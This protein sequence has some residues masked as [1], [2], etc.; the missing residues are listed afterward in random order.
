MRARALGAVAP[1]VERYRRDPSQPGG[2]LGAALLALDKPPGISSHGV[3][4]RVRRALRLRAVGHLGTLDPNASGLL[5]CAL[6][7]C[8][9]AAQ[10]WQGGDKTYRGTLVLGVVTDSQDL[11]GRV[12]ER[13]PAAVDEHAVR[14]AAAEF[15][16]E[17]QQVPPMVSALRRGGRRLYELARRGQEVERAPRGVRVDRFEVESVEAGRVTFTVRCSPGTY[18]RTLAHDLGQALGCGAALESLRRLRSEPF[19]LER[20]LAG[21]ELLRLPAAEIVARCGYTL[22]ESLAHLPALDLGRDS[23][24]EIGLGAAPAVEAGALA[25]GAGPLSVV[26]RGPDGWIAA[27]GE[28][29]PGDGRVLARPHL[30]FPWAVREGR[31]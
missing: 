23:I 31:A 10:V 8:T 20:A 9:R 22:R 26:F 30:V 24:A 6:G 18:V 28:L 27:L 17:R 25:L 5:L 14:A 7:P 2:P 21:D 16:G 1:Q 12:L 3:V 15:V 29:V 19:G 11:W 4:L 13:R